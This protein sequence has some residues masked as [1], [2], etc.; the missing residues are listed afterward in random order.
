[1]TSPNSDSPIVP[2]RPKESWQHFVVPFFGALIVLFFVVLLRFA[3]IP[4]SVRNV[5]V[6]LTIPLL[7]GGAWWAIFRAD[8][9]ADEFQ[10]AYSRQMESI[11]FRF[12][13]FWI[14]AGEFLDAAG[15]EWDYFDGI[16]GITY[17]VLLGAVLTHRRV[18]GRKR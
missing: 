7:V 11:A 16:K 14:L 18:Y 17:G 8:R 3:E 10:L 13:V 15:L 2:T 1:M 6:A 4:G 12:L 9:F 5:F